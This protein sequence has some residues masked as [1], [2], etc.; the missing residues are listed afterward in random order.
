[1]SQR[2][3]CPF[4]G[5]TTFEEESGILV[6]TSC[7]RQQE[8]G[9]QVADDD[10]DFGTQGKIT[11]KKVEKTKFKVS[12]VYRGARGYRLYLLAWQNILWRQCYA[13][14]HGTSDVPEDLWTIVKDLWTLKLGGLEYR[15][16]DHGRSSGAEMDRVTE[17]LASDSE[18]DDASTSNRTTYLQPKLW[19]T[20][21]LVY[22]GSLLL[23]HPICLSKLYRLIRNEKLPFIRA[24]RHVPTEISSKLPSEYQLALDTTTIP[25]QQDL[26][27]AVYKQFQ[28]YTQNFSMILPALS[29]KIILFEWIQEL[30]LPI[31]IYGMVKKLA[32]LVSYE[33]TYELTLHEKSHEGQPR[34]KRRSPVAMPE[35]Q[36][37]SLIVVATK[38][39]YPFK[40]STTLTTQE[41]ASPS[42]L[43][44]DWESW[45][46]IHKSHLR[47]ETSVMQPSQAIE[48]ASN[49]IHKLGPEALDQYMDWYEATF[50]TPEPVLKAKKTNLE[51]S[52]LDMFPLS[53][54]DP[55]PRPSLEFEDAPPDERVRT[56]SL[57]SQLQ[58][59]AIFPAPAPSQPDHP[60]IAPEDAHPP[61]PPRARYQIFPNID[62]LQ[63]TNIFFDNDVSKNYIVYF[64][65]Q[66]AE[67]ACLDL[68]KLLR[69]TRYTEK[70]LEGWHSQQ[71][72]NEALS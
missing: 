3:P 69:A 9:L 6:C 65:E 46:A 15:L 61:S 27:N 49:D 34:R 13:L 17:D 19:D 32:E 67:L 1:M 16:D 68:K 24:I 44:I 18:V 55:I 42:G 64:H 71:R 28:D 60:D 25:T 21:A 58:H 35:T 51:N 23:R 63:A 43:R 70:R 52:I 50:T 10:A 53:L 4:C 66:A 54:S 22:L 36:L 38:L 2:Q 29:W 11:R 45:S 7:G 41:K 20:I 48:T 14:I 5:N 26:H 57:V 12:K 33:F 37:I 62:T 39:L 30:G 72:R 31:E 59:E 40:I 56:M 47:H 8:G